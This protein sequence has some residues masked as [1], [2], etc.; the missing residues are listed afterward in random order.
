[1]ADDDRA[2]SPALTRARAHT[3]THI[4]KFIYLLYRIATS[5]GNK[6]E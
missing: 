3:H 1:M 5:P 6:E 4:N 2:L